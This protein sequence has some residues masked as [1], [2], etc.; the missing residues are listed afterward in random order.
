MEYNVTVR[1][2]CE[3]KAYQDNLRNIFDIALRK[4]KKDYFGLGDLSEEQMDDEVLG[5]LEEL[6]DRDEPFGTVDLCYSDIEM[7]TETD[8]Y[9]ELLFVTGREGEEFAREIKRWLGVM[10]IDELYVECSEPV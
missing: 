6:A 1:F 9:V 7:I 10:E 8:G 5:R 4:G 3:D 2:S